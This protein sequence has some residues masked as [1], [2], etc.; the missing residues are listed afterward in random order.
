MSGFTSKQIDMVTACGCCGTCCP[1]MPTQ[2]TLALT[3]ISMNTECVCIDGQVVPME[4]AAQ[5][6]GR[7]YYNAIWKMTCIINGDPSQRFWH[8]FQ[9]NCGAGDVFPTVLVSYMQIAAG[10]TPT[11][12]TDPRWS[13]QVFTWNKISGQC[14]PFYFRFASTGGQ[15]SS[16]N[17]Q[18]WGQCEESSMDTPWIEFEV[19]L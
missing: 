4:L 5:I 1:G 7:V 18:I 9:M 15:G 6:G 11:G 12:V 16:G 10:D 8:L 17:S 19:T 2:T 13:G 3:L 14:D